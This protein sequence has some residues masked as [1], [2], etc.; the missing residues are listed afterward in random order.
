MLE[1]GR[2]RRARICQSGISNHPLYETR[3]TRIT[4]ITQ[5]CRDADNDLQVAGR[6]PGQTYANK[7]VHIYALTP[8]NI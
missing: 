4:I 2:L 8:D 7:Y 3:S 5:I 1:R 6:Y